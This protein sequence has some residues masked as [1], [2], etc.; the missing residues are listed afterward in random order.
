MAGKVDKGARDFLSQMATGKTL[1]GGL[2]VQVGV[3]GGNHSGERKSPAH[4]T[5]TK[6]GNLRIQEGET[7][8]PPT[9]AELALWL[10]E[11]IPHNATPPRPFLS[12]RLNGELPAVKRVIA[13]LAKAIMK[14][15][16]TP[17]QAAKFLGEWG[18]SEVVEGINTREYAPN[19]A[20]TIAKKGS[21]S[22]LIDT[23]ELKAAIS[24]RIKAS[25]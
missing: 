14:G 24:F 22:A 5:A 15:L 4:F 18:R 9:N 16:I 25:Q 1:K 7:L 19:A 17:E 12:Q 20:S 13:K 6:D 11:G 8:R 21:D 10:H 3:F 2:Q 23:G